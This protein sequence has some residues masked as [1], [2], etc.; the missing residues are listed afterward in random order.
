MHGIGDIQDFPLGIGA[1][2]KRWHTL[3][4]DGVFDHWGN[5]PED[6]WCNSIA[7][8]EFFLNPLADTA[9]VGRQ[10]ALRQFGEAAGDH[11]FTA[12][13]A[14]E[15]AHVELS[16][17]CTWSPGQWPGWYEGRKHWPLPGHFRDVGLRAHQAP[18]RQEG[19]LT[20]NPADF[21]EAL[22]AVSDA[23][24]RARPHYLAAVGAL[25]TAL[26]CATD[27]PVFYHFWWNGTG[28]APTCREHIRR[29]LLHLESMA[30]P[31]NEIG[32]HFG[33]HALWETVDHDTADF[34]TKAE[35]LL[36]A[37]IVACRAAEEFFDRLGKPKDWGRLYAAKAQAMA[38]YLK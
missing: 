35:S 7:C 27:A 30:T 25:R 16:P 36:R 37:D 19:D 38:E 28:P 21:A 1:K 33:L 18:S 13:A 29:Q 23:W 20:F 24:A 17:T 9:M 8:R 14:L 15:R 22:Q 26:A 2:I 31:G 12:W 11:V 10:I 32:L 3:D 6:I 4:A 5:A 34:R